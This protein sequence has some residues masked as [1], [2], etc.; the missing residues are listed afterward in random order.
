MLSTTTTIIISLSAPV[1]ALLVVFVVMN[2]TMMSN[3]KIYKEKYESLRNGVYRFDARLGDHIYFKKQGYNSEN[4]WFDYSHREIIFFP[5]GDIKLEENVY[6]HKRLIMLHLYGWYYWR[7]F[8]RLKDHLIQQHNFR[9]AYRRMSGDHYE[10][11]MKQQR[12]RTD[13]K[14]LRG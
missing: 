10:R 9:E 1:L 7:K 11:Y 12:Q 8:Q 13:F 4:V 2:L 3:N 5:D 14:F 6:I